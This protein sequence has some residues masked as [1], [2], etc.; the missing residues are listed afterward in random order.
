[1]PLSKDSKSELI[2][3]L[4]L[5]T[6]SAVFFLLFART[7]LGLTYGT[8]ILAIGLFLCTAQII[9]FALLHRKYLRVWNR[10]EKEKKDNQQRLLKLAQNANIV[11]E[12]SKAALQEKER[13]LLN[14][15]TTLPGVVYQFFARP[16]G[17]TGMYF[18]SDKS[19]DVLG[20]DPRDPYFVENITQSF[21]PEDR[22][23]FLASIA[24]A[25]QEC[26]EWRFEG[27]RLRPDGSLHWIRGNSLP[28]RTGDEIVFTGFLLDITDSKL[29]QQELVESQD[30]FSK[31]FNLSPE[32]I[33]ITRI[34]DGTILDG[35]PAATQLT[36]YTREEFLGKTVL[37]LL[38]DRRPE[39]ICVVA[40]TKAL[41]RK[42]YAPAM[43]LAGV[44]H[45]MLE[46]SGTNFEP[47][48][49][50]LHKGEQ[51]NEDYKLLNPRSQ[52]SRSPSLLS[53]GAG[54]NLKIVRPLTSTP[55]RLKSSKSA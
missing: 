7:L 33:C 15:I 49:V 48:M 8:L 18:V 20:M 1:M 51:Y 4:F 25:I 19:R 40:R 17:T 53:V 6:V 3:W 30:K 41:L 28:V 29:A 44:P 27:R 34:S 16:D 12:Q 42:S 43:E 31:F 36:G 14:T 39:D 2:F 22:P 37:D 24:Q 13:T 23:L 45:V 47:T 35:N 5:L 9:A 21:V 38:K 10:I 32:M 26:T 11:M 52:V 46:M 50:K 55:A 54:K